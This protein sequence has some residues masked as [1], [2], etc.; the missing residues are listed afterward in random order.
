MSGALLNFSRNIKDLLAKKGLDQTEFADSIKLSRTLFS[1]YM[2]GKK[3]P[4]LKQLQRIADEL[5]TSVSAL[6][7]DSMPIT[8][9]PRPPIPEEMALAV[10]DAFKLP[11]E[12]LEAIKLILEADNL[13]AVDDSR[14]FLLSYL[15]PFD[16][17]K[18]RATNE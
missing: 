16:K 11:K 15:T 13:A 5:G 1:N 9:P 17:G 2:R 8:A 4:G 12:K 18:R 10:L 7:G 3:I 14:K 6:V